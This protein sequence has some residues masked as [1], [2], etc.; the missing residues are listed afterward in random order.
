MGV[1]GQENKMKNLSLLCCQG[2]PQL[3]QDSPSTCFLGGQNCKN[4]SSPTCSSLHLLG[5]ESSPGAGETWQC[6]PL[7]PC[8]GQGWLCWGQSPSLVPHCF[9]V[10]PLEQERRHQTTSVSQPVLHLPRQL[11]CLSP[12]GCCGQPRLSAALAAGKMGT[13]A[14]PR[15]RKKAAA[16]P[17]SLGWLL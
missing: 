13:R 6:S 9:H 10:L 17:R 2:L 3:C 7:Q 1:P 8:C 12:G 5:A 15:V 16:W 4:W 11:C 14:E